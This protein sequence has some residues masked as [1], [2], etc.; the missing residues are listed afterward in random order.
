LKGERKGEERVVR[1]NPEMKRRLA[2]KLRE[3]WGKRGKERGKEGR[4]EI[5]REW[6]REGERREI[7]T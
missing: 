6:G 3:R 5:E 4:H 7:E 1:G 2:C